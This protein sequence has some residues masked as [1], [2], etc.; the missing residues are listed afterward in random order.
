MSIKH[1]LNLPFIYK[2]FRR[3][4]GDDNIRQHYADQFICAR[5]GMRV[6]DIGCGT[7][8]ILRFLPL[9]DYLGFDLSA[10]DIESAKQ[11][12]GDRGRFFCS[13][14]DE[15]IDVLEASFDIVLAHGV[16]HHLNDQEALKLFAIALRALKPGGRLVTFD[17]CFTDDQSR[18]ARFFVSKDRGQHIRNRCGYEDLAKSAFSSPR[19]TIRH[20][21]IRLPYTHIIMEC[22]K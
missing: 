14:V 21:L 6:L 17:G 10:D 18:L 15:S 1:V 22:T 13:P 7:G 16:L 3:F 2:F 19:V 5:D 20:D 11:K 12:F 4:I 9:V 8:D